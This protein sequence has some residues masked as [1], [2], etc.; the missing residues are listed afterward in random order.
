LPNDAGAGPATGVTPIPKALIHVLES[1]LLRELDVAGRSPEQLEALRERAQHLQQ[2]SGD[3]RSN[4]FIT[5][6]ASYNGQS[7]EIEGL[8]GL[9]IN[10]RPFDWVDSDIDDARL[11]LAQLAQKFILD[12]AFAHVDNRPDKRMRM[13]VVV[14]LHGQPRAMQ[15]EFDVTDRDQAEIQDLIAK[16]DT[17]LANADAPRKNI[18]LA[19]LAELTARYMQDTGATTKRKGRGRT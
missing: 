17:A 14:P 8:A 9:A 7:H 5:R 10:K 19:A 18:M 2:L 16:V 1:A 11:K 4:A 12:E 15:R 6:L 3:F 13:A